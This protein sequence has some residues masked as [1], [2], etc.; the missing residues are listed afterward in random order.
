VH[1]ARLYDGVGGE[2]VV[3]AAVSA[4][5]DAVSLLAVW[6]LVA[7]HS[8]NNAVCAAVRWSNKIDTI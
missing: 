1:V 4:H 2:A 3:V 7:K 5:I 8:S 6:S